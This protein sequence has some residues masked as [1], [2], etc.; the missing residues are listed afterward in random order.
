MLQRKVE[1]QRVQREA[2]NCFEP[3]R[4]LSSHLH[5]KRGS[6]AALRVL[7][8]AMRV[9]ILETELTAL[10]RKSRASF[11]TDNRCR[12]R[13]QITTSNHIWT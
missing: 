9:P 13:K 4:D 6:A 5:D 7:D 11:A 8:S 1:G 3:R 10:G 12:Q 2:L